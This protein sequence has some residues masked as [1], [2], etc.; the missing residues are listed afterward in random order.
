MLQVDWPLL[1]LD[2]DHS[3]LESGDIKRL[4]VEVEWALRQ[5]VYE[6]LKRVIGQVF[7]DADD[8]ASATTNFINADQ[9]VRVGA[10]KGIRKT[11]KIFDDFR[12]LI[13]SRLRKR[14][15]VTLEIERISLLL[16]EQ[17][18]KQGWVHGS[19]VSG[20]RGVLFKRQLRM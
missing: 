11:E 15:L 12:F 4:I 17:A 20:I 18:F 3:D 9:D 16:V 13:V 19:T 7:R 2:A 10:S 1:Q 5:V 14:V 8:V 6:L